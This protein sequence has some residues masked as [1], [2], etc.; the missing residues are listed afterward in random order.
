MCD[1][2]ASATY[3]RGSVYQEVPPNTDNDNNHLNTSNDTD[4]TNDNSANHDTI[5]N[6][7]HNIDR[8]SN[9]T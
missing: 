9:N 4:N 2:G 1:K 6:H 3:H 5:T 7:I 8:T